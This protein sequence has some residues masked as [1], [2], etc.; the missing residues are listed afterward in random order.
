M[1]SIVDPTISLTVPVPPTLSLTLRSVNARSVSRWLT[2]LVPIRVLCV[3][4]GSVQQP[5]QASNHLRLIAIVYQRI[6]RVL[7]R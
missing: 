1:T 6:S 4:N 2:W 7:V 3:D 5:L